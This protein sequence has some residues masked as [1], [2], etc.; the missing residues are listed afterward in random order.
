MKGTLDYGLIYHGNSEAPILQVYTDA[1]WAS[2]TVD[3]RSVS[4]ALFKLFGS[5]VSW[6][7]KKQATISLSS[8]E[9]ELVALCSAACQNQWLVR[10]LK[11]IGLEMNEPVP[12]FEDNQSTINIVC[13]QRDLGRMKHIDVKHCFVRKLVENGSIKLHYVPTVDQVADI[14]T[15]GLP[16][17]AFRKLRTSLGLYDCKI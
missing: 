16:A 9:A 5:T 15:K 14:L 7:A 8:T 4:G 13:N 1:D 11:N 12:F 10:I 2:D 6:T 17:P 3:R